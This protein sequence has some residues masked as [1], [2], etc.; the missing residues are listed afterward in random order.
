MNNVEKLQT[1]FC[2]SGRLSLR[3]FECV[4]T[5]FGS[6]SIQNIETQQNK[7]TK[8]IVLLLYVCQN[9]RMKAFGRGAQYQE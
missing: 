1:A 2:K 9:K 8:Y 4:N 5:L 7:S 3:Y 6:L